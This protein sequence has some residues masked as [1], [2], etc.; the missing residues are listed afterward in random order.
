LSFVEFRI[1][2]RNAV[3]AEAFS[4]ELGAG[5]REENAAKQKP[6]APA[7]IPPKPERL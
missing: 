2:S 6:G 1:A 4:S 7:L 5:S 3:P